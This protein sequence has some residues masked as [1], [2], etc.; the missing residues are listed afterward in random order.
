MGRVTDEVQRFL[1]NRAI[2]G[3]GVIAVSGG[4]DSIALLRALHECECCS[5]TVAHV[6]HQLRGE[7]SDADE[8]F[9]RELATTLDM[10][11]R[12]TRVDMAALAQRENLEATARD[13]RYA[14]LNE[15][16]TEVGASWIATGHTADDQAETV[17]HRLLRGTGLQGLRGVAACKI[18]AGIQIIRPMLAVTRSDVLYYLRE[19]HQ[20]FRTDSSNADPRFTRNRI[21][22]EL[23]P[24]LRTFNPA[25]TGSLTQLAEQA[26]EAFEV[27]NTSASA[28]L[29]EMELPR[30]GAV[31]ILDALTLTTA[32]PYRVREALRLLWQ[33]E[34]WP[35]DR[36]GFEHWNRLVAVACGELRAADFP[37]GIT[38]R[39]TGKVVQLIRHN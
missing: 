7:E 11:C 21:R 2:R 31:L 9:V 1:R 13:F 19:L 29:A 12:L 4:A 8:A 16:A 28:L 14:W 25:I 34:R 18:M 26:A 23:V 3:P 24:L 17:L 6:N 22:A 32:H 33:R 27:L 35:A 30:A 36:M 39:H 15:I 37:G 10:S 38:A 20:P 5:L